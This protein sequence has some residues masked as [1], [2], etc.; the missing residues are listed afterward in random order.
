MTGIEYRRKAHDPS[1]LSELFLER[2]T[3]GD[4]EGLVQLYEADA[5][6]ALFGGGVAIGHAK[7]RA[8]YKDATSAPVSLRPGRQNLTVVQGDLALTSTTHDGGPITAEV[9]RRQPD[10][11]W[12]WILD[13]PNLA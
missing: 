9:A 4:V 10:G 2:F 3:N 12:L 1:Q 8:A 5:V 11:T 6:L 13:N 7:I